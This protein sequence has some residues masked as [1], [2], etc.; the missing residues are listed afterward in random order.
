MY[1]HVERTSKCANI[2]GIQFLMVSGWSSLV[3]QWVKE[4][5]LTLLW[6]RLL[7]WRRFD[8]QPRNFR[9]ARVWPKK[10]KNNNG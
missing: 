9:M 3:V 2:Y 1:F 10:E 5:V 8:P 6:L 4:L 7:L